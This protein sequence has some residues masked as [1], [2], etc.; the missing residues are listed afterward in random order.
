[1]KDGLMPLKKTLKSNQVTNQTQIELKL[2][3]ISQ[4]M[5][6]S[7]LNL[8]QEYNG[9]NVNPSKKLEINA[10]VVLAGLSDVLKLFLIESVLLLD[11][12][13]KPESLLKTYLP[14]AN[15]VEEDVEEVTQ[16][17]LGTISLKQVSLPEI[18]MIRI[19]I[20]NPTSLLHATHIS[21]VPNTQIAQPHTLLPHNVL[22]NV[23]PNSQEVLIAQISTEED[24]HTPSKEFLKSKEN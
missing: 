14:V 8:T 7:Q 17:L 15:H 2:T 3:L 11:K 20:V 5:V 22:N 9:Q 6:K 12:S 4:K 16:V 1:M 24:H 19:N 23:T 10:T 21:T 13:N 18:Y